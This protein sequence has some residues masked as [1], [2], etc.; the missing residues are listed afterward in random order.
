MLCSWLVGVMKPKHHD[1]LLAATL[2]NQSV[3][4]SALT[5]HVTHLRAAETSARMQLL[6]LNVLKNF[7]VPALADTL[8]DHHK[9]P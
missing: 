8:V 3:Q 2:E 1:R 6:V 7:D 4:I 9:V 5:K